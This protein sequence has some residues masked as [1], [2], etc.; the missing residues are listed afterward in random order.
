[1]SRSRSDQS[2]RV[3]DSLTNSEELSCGGMAASQVEK[4]V[5]IPWAS[6]VST[7]IC[8]ISTKMCWVDIVYDQEWSRVHSNTLVCELQA[9]SKVLVFPLELKSHL[10]L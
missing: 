6:T 2:T 3:P 4:R 7:I 5:G 8:K 1:M 9:I 10:D